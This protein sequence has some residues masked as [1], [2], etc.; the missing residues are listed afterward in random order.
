MMQ[1][2]RERPS[3]IIPLIELQNATPEE[4]DKIRESARQEQQQKL[5]YQ[6]NI[7]KPL[8]EVFGIKS[9]EE[10]SK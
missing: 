10:T 1:K 3:N 7:N 4:L 6:K 2:M 9:S 8:S 5:I